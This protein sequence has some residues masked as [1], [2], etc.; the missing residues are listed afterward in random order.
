LALQIVSKHREH[1]HLVA[2]GGECAG[3]IVADAGDSSVNPEKGEMLRMVF[4]WKAVNPH[5]SFDI[6]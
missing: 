6:N 5:G 3:Y 2:E 1:R 4:H